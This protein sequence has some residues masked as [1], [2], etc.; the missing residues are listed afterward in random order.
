[1][2]SLDDLRTYLTS[3]FELV[4]RESNEEIALQRLSLIRILLEHFHE[5]IAPMIREAAKE[6]KDLPGKARIT[7][8]KVLEELRY[9]SQ[10]LESL[11][12]IRLNPE[13]IEEYNEIDKL[14][15]CLEKLHSSGANETRKCLD[16][17][18]DKGRAYKN[19]LQDL[20]AH[21]RFD[22]DGQ[23]ASYFNPKLYRMHLVE[24]QLKEKVDKLHGVLSKLKDTLDEL[25]KTAERV[26]KKLGQIEICANCSVSI[27][28]RDHIKDMATNVFSDAELLKFEHQK[29]SEV[30]RMVL[31]SKDTVEERLR[32]LSSAV[33]SLLDLSDAEA[34]YKACY[35]LT[36]E[37][38]SKA[39][40]VLDIEE[41]KRELEAAR[42]DLEAVENQLAGTT[43]IKIEPERLIKHIKASEKL[44]HEA[45]AELSRVTDRV[46][47][48]WQS[49]RSSRMELINNFRSLIILLAGRYKD[50][51][52]SQLTA[53]LD[54]LEKILSV[55]SLQ[56]V[57]HSVS[58]LEDWL[59]SI[60]GRFEQHIGDILSPSE[61]RILTYLA[62]TTSPEN[63]W[64]R[65]SDLA[66]SLEL[67]TKKDE[68]RDILAKLAREGFCECGISLILYTRKEKTV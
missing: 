10:T 43:G 54:S 49:Y 38:L 23:Q 46:N 48:L 24:E 67:G 55:E 34:K 22:R 11:F 15:D 64:I 21:F 9:I 51:D 3:E 44:L 17:V 62:R 14:R 18:T 47:A 65:F 66:S 1:M 40:S 45:S 36:K 20:Q 56:D 68:L 7:Q 19:S 27:S 37:L 41:Y 53:Q 42:S 28:I 26:K 25:T 59:N 16:D 58:E 32:E 12:R 2:I 50:I 63:P 30:Q 29:L 57:D 33:E 60:K 4:G 8:S 35:D 13:N 39:S 31:K 61:I 5:E 6:G 52:F